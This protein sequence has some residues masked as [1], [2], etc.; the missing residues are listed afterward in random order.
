[1]NFGLPA[2]L[3]LFT[4]GLKVGL[5]GGSFNPPHEGHRAAS[6]LALHRLQLDRI[7]WLV[8]PANPLKDTRE[9]APL[10]LRVAA[11][12][13]VSRHP[14]I[15]V[16]AIETA[17]GAR[18]SFETVAYLKRRC[19]GVHFVWLMGA[20]NFVQFSLWQRWREIADLIPI[21][22]IDR[23]GSI[24]AALQGAPAAALAPYRFDES[25]GPCLPLASPPAILFL[26]G[27]RSP[28]SST[29]LRGKS[30]TI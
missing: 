7:W 12:R 17:I 15:E 30:Q 20:D 26:H 11:A 24:F 14:R 1:M 23:P 8:S 9:L 3:P 25:D 29:Q 18:Y 10:P 4:R 19:P 22:I 21:A 28:Q 27:P 16:T 2:K 6:L 13:K 5:F